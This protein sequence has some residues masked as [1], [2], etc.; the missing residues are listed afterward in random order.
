ML[1]LA[2]LFVLVC[3][4]LFLVLF[5]IVITSLGEERTDRCDSRA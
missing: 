5:R 3:V 2:L 1:S 4:F